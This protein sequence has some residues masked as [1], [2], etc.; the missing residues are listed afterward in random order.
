MFKLVGEN[1]LTGNKWD[2]ETGIATRKEA[3]ELRKGWSRLESD[4]KIA[5]Y[6]EEEK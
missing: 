5:Y 1:M 2:C 6:V 3:V 4:Y